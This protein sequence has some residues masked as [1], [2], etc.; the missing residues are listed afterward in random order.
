MPPAE[1]DIAREVHR[2]AAERLSPPAAAATAAVPVAA[3]VRR[4]A[5]NTPAATD[6][7]GRAWGIIEI[8]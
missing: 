1:E 2:Y 6:A 7:H 8:D 3:P 5:A 4:G